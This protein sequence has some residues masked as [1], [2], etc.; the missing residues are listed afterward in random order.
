[1]NGSFKCCNN[2]SEAKSTPWLIPEPPCLVYVMAL[3]CYNLLAVAQAAM[4]SLH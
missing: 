4:R 3:I 1:M 2:V